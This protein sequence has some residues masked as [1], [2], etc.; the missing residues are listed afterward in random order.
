MKNFIITL[1]LFLIY[2][3][4]EAQQKIPS[5]DTISQHRNSVISWRNNKDR[6]YKD[7][8]KTMLTKELL[9]SFKGLHYFDINYDYVI[10]GNLVKAKE[11]EIITI[12]TST[13]DTYE[14]LVYGT[15]RFNL[16]GKEHKLQLYQSF[17]A[18]REG[19]KKNALFLPFT[20]TT[21]GEDSYGG[22]RYL[23]LDV[24]ETDQM[25]LDFNMAYN[26]YC[27]YDP[28]HSCPVPPSENH[29]SVKIEAG[30]KMYP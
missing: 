5:D 1:L 19:R 18:A 29:L 13:G 15:V 6:D 25:V 4:A 8:N 30:E 10:K 16:H 26:P 23:V 21:S 3:G 11:E 28:D 12:V 20:D 17:S 2:K 24:P 22:G 7:K 27:V 9:E 14:N